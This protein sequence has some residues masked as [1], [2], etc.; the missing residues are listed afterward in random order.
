MWCELGEAVQVLAYAY[1]LICLVRRPSAKEGLSLPAMLGFVSLHFLRLPA[2]WRVSRWNETGPVTDCAAFSCITLALARAWPLEVQTSAFGAD[3]LAQVWPRGF[4]KLTDTTRQLASFA[5]LVMLC[6]VIGA[7]YYVLGRNTIAMDDEYIGFGPVR[8]YLSQ[9]HL[10]MEGLVLLPQVVHIRRRGKQEVPDVLANFLAIVSMSQV[11]FVI[12]G[13]GAFGYMA[14]KLDFQ[15]LELYY[16]I[17][18]AAN[19]A[20]FADFLYFYMKSR[21]AGVALVLPG[22]CV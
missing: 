17:S 14:V 20:I 2:P 4:V 9:V 15:P 18:H 7:A 19:L 8:S 12:S 3:V 22:A 16:T 10:A 1:L 11:F 5:F 13:A 6:T 21:K